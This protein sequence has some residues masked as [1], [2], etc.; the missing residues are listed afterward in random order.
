MTFIVKAE[1][2]KKHAECTHLKKLVLI[3]DKK[4]KAKSKFAK[5]LTD[6]TFFDKINDDDD[7]E[8]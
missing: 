3:S 8:Q 4:P 7:L 6:K 2:K 5:S 1:K